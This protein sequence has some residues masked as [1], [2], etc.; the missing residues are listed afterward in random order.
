MAMTGAGSEGFTVSTWDG[1]AAQGTLVRADC[2]AVVDLD[3]SLF[4]A[5]PEKRKFKGDNVIAGAATFSGI[6]AADAD[7]AA[8]RAVF[9]DAIARVAGVDK[10]RVMILSIEASS[11]GAASRILLWSSSRSIPASARPPA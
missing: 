9:R 4:M 8:A 3:L 11:R 1:D 2:D 10:D 5:S 6:T 7:T